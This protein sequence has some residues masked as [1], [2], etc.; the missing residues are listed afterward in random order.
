MISSSKFFLVTLSIAAIAIFGSLQTAAQP[1]APPPPPFIDDIENIPVDFNEIAAAYAYDRS[2]PL[3]V[4]ITNK[5]DFPSFTKIYFSYDS[6]NGGRV[7]A[8]IMMPKNHVKPMKEERATVPGAFP[9]VFFMHFHVADKSMADIFSTWPGYGLAVMAIDGVFRGGREEKNKDI[10][11]PDPV[12]SAK[13]MMMQVKDILRGFDALAQWEGIDPGRIGYM[14]ISMGAL[15]G[16]VAT[17]LDAR[18]KSIILA[19]GAADFSLIFDQSDYGS[20]QEIKKYMND[21]GLKKR[22]LME[23]FKFVEPAVFA[24]RITGRPVMFMNGEEDTTMTLPAMKKLHE[25]TGSDKKKVLWYK[26]G[27]ILPVE[28]IPSDALKWFR[29]TL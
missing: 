25:V 16:T 15:T 6:L 1:L 26:S 20:L 23:T 9:V 28:K 2:I 7:P 18:V 14:G 17:A 22:D 12:V 24:P 8:V 10:L 11:E 4:E 3:N 29:G 21:R 19:D 13:H 5:Q 27:H